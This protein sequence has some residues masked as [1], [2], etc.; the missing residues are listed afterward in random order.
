MH[1]RARTWMVKAVFPTPPSPSTTS[2]Y[3]V[4]ILPAITV[5]I[6]VLITP[7]LYCDSFSEVCRDFEIFRRIA[8]RGE[9]RGERL[10]WSEKGGYG[11]SEVVRRKVVRRRT[12]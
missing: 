5:S 9:I 1:Q 6:N 11:E 4:I 12:R 8:D 7:F 2:L 10:N 3:N